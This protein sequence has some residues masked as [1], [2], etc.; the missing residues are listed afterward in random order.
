MNGQLKNK[1]GDAFIRGNNVRDQPPPARA[2]VPV[3][4][5]ALPLRDCEEWASHTCVGVVGFVHQ[6]GG[7]EKAL[8]C[9]DLDE[10]F[11]EGSGFGIWTCGVPT[12][13]WHDVSCG[14]ERR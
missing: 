13:H 10:N 5:T 4:R 9:S 6:H 2:P 14:A 1:Y 3:L 8:N 12:G 7:D 11:A